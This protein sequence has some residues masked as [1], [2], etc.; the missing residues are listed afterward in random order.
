MM[1]N[2]TRQHEHDNLMRG[3]AVYG[4]KKHGLS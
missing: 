3:I 4:G 1:Q 2:M